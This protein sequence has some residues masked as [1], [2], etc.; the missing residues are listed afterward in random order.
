MKFKRACLVEPGK[1]QLFEVE[2]EPGQGEVLMKIAGCGLCN[3]EL[4]FWDGQLNFQ[5]YPHKLG[6]EFAGEIVAVGPGCKKLKVGDK[7]SAVDRGFGGFAEYRVTKEDAC[8]KLADTID[9]TYAMGE[10]QKCIVTV[11]RAAAPEA[12]DYGVILGVGPM[13]M[14]CV[15]GLKANT[16]SGLIAV[17][18][19]DEKLTMAKHF[20]ATHTINSRNE[21]AVQRIREITGGHMADF[22]IE[23]SGIPSL[24]NAAQDYL[25]VGKGRL[26]LMSSHHDACQFDFRKAVDKGLEFRI[27]H[28]PYS[29]NERDDFRRA[30][31]LINN[32][33]F[34]SEP[35]VTHVFKLSDIQT[36][37]ETLANKPKGFM[38]GLVVPD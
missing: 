25:K 26:I 13:G 15:Q 7:V 27:A 32:G 12:G 24:L 3:W 20:G 1:F 6:H 19:D 14:W 9:P 5:G 37:F 16:L 2:E 34:Q 11:L 30:V 38:K 22:V 33:V 28:P 10:P 17:D 18:V 31:S 35:L 4:N 8:E 21:D 36:A 29:Q 23:G